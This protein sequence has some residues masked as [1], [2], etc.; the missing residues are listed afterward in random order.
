MTDVPGDLAEEREEYGDP[1]TGVCEPPF[2]FF[3]LRHFHFMW[4]I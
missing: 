2:L 3:F 4:V 1:A